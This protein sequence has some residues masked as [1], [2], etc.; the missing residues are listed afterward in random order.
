M[1]VCITK[2]A[3]AER[4]KKTPT[5]QTDISSTYTVGTETTCLRERYDSVCTLSSADSGQYV[6]CWGLKWQILSVCVSETTVMRV[7]L[8]LQRY[9]IHLWNQGDPRIKHLH[10]KVSWETGVYKQRSTTPVSQILYN[11]HTKTM[12]VSSGMSQEVTKLNIIH[13]M[14]L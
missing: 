10:G 7:T 14:F 12:H 13:W 6:M 8:C 5:L 4:K 2:V 3:T 9:S 11:T 1:S